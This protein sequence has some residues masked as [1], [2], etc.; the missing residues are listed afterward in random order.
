MGAVAD[1]VVIVE[2]GASEMLPL[3]DAGALF[4]AMAKKLGI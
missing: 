3:A 2:M 4:G 1:A